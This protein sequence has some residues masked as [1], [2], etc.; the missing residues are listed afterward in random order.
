MAG[1]FLAGQINGT[2]GYE[3]AGA[4]GL[5]AGMNA[6][7]SASGQD[8]AVIGRADAYLGV[9]IDDLV[10]NGV[11][12]PYRMFTSRAEYRLSLR[13]DNADQRLTALGERLGI[14]GGRRA[15]L[16]RNK[17]SALASGRK[18]VE[19][20]M[21]TPSEASRHGLHINQDGVRR[22]AFELLAR[23]DISLGRL[24]EIWP[25]L[26][27]LD[28]FVCEQIELDAKY[29][30]YLD[31]QSADIEGFR[32]DEAVTIPDAVDYGLLV[33]AFERIA[34]EAQGGATSD[35][36]PGGARRWDDTGGADDPGCRGEASCRPT[37]CLRQVHR[38]MDRRRWPVLSMFHVKRSIG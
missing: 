28:R 16:F 18:M 15:A 8:G 2:T 25:E 34:G 37:G 24:T 33:R 14:V 12:E 32:R 21:L 1:L 27:G 17:A 31:R 26:R 36:G 6:A 5:V 35:L 22:S 3:E 19:T 20:L 13:A 4:Q 38:P 29:A 11:S 10:T 30:V 9:M 7:R 23:P